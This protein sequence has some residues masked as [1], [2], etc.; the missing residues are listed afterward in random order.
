MLVIETSS[1]RAESEAQF[2]KYNLSVSFD[3]KKNLVKGN[4]TFFMSGERPAFLSTDGLN[5]LS[6]KLDG[7]PARYKNIPAGIEISGKGVAEI[8]Y[9]AVFKD[10][11]G[12]QEPGGSGVAM[13]DSVSEQGIALTENWYPSLSGLALYNLTANVPNGFSAISE[14]ENITFRETSSGRE[15]SFNFP[16]PLDGIDFVAGN[17]QEKKDIVNGIEVFTY[18]FPEDSALSDSYMENAKKYLKMY[19]ELLVPYPYKRFSVVENIMPTGLSMPTFTLLGREVVRLPFITETSLGH[20]ITHQWFG[21]YVYGGHEGGNWLEA[22]TTY[23]SDHYYEEQKGAGWEYR[24]KIMSDYQSYVTPENDFPLKEFT[25]RKD[26]SSMAIGYGKGAMLFHMLKNT[27]G[28]EMFFLSLKRLIKDNEF[29]KASWAD[30]QK[31][32]ERGS[33]KDLG[34]FFGQ[35]LNRKGVAEVSV[36]DGRVLVLEGIPTVSFQLLQKGEP[37]TLSLPLVIKGNKVES[38][39]LIETGETKKYFRI[40]SEENPGAMVLDGNY[41]VMRKLSR[42][43]FPPV[44]S[45]LLGSDKKIVIYENKD[46][47]KFQELIS[48]CEKKG[49]TA[50]NETEVKDEDIRTSSL[51]VLGFESAVLK[52]LFGGVGRRGPGFVLIVKENPLNASRVVAYCDGDSKDEVSLSAA[53]IF[54]YGK[55]SVLRFE[56]GRNVAKET[57]TSERGMVSALYEPVEGVEPVKSLRLDKIIDEIGGSPVIIV[58]ERHTNY[59]DHKVELDIITALFKKGKKFA[60]GME[61]FQ[62]PFQSAID[63]YIAGVITEKEFLKKTEYFKRWRFD[64]N[65]YREILEFAKAKGIPVVALNLRSEIIEKVAKGG[66]DSLTEAEKKEIPADMDM[67]DNLYRDRL[68]QIYESHPQGTKFENF[69]QAQILWDETMAHS[70]ADFLDGK[71]GYQMVIMAGGE[72]V[73]YDSGVPKRVGRLTGQKYITLVNGDF[74]ADIGSY[75]L[76]PKELTPPFTAKMGVVLKDTKE[77]A[78]VEEFSPSSIALKA[79]LKKGDAIVSIDDWKVGSSEDVKIAFFD[80]TPGQTVKVTVMRKRFLMGQKKME[81]EVTF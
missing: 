33:G 55:Y 77:G 24:K 57:E 36:A 69:Y 32:F 7:S 11:Q 66:L 19:S 81:F 68:R 16:H 54:H 59:E 25:Q 3:L 26:A 4:A 67:S 78:V 30:I 49:F 58:G 44:L 50:R 18:F 21:N 2:P 79:G 70:A 71:P 15:Y 72:H 27:V 34:W 39:S 65:L 51:L 60:I 9:E 41:D 45:R 75:V 73:K 63:E 10:N 20:E 42:E 14:A 37:Y 31:S 38:K 22:I 76:F 74:D 56:R 53:K 12:G 40:R 62:R 80:I 1:A 35:W 61:M 13:A 8:S 52:R 43:E 23:L 64:Y 29:R 47:E 17:Y 5:I 28:D 48:I 6:V 46:K